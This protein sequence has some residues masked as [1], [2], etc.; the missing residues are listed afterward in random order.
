VVHKQKAGVTAGFRRSVFRLARLVRGFEH[1]GFLPGD[2][3]LD[4]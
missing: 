3:A 4:G 2:R 1:G